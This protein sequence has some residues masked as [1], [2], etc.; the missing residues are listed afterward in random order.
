M[1]LD[2]IAHPRLL[3]DMQT[4]AKAVETAGFGSIWLTEGAR[5]A[6]LSCAAA[7]LATDRLQ[8]GTGIALAFARSPMVTAEIAWELADATGGRFVLGLGSQVKAHIERRYSAEFSPP[9]P[10]MKEYVKAVK[11]IFRAF[12]G[13]EKLAFEGRYYNFSLL[14]SMW[15]PGPIE[16][17]DPPIYVSAVLPYMSRL[18]GEI[19]DGIHVHPFHSPAFVRDVQRVS[20]EEGLARSG[21]N[22][23]A[24]TFQCPIMTAVGDSDEELSKTREHA[25][26]MIAFYGSTR[27]YSPVFEHHG[28]AGLSDELHARQKRGDMKG[29][30]GL[31]SDEVLEPYIVT[32]SWNDLGPKLVERYRDLAPKV[33]VTSYTAAENFDDPAAREKWSHVAAAMRAA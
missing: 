10:R 28:F 3:R 8:I 24:I 13:E 6:Y 17:P 23:D 21:R 19:A 30:I 22:L 2:I 14:P 4:H 26:T 11:A 31:V 29:M 25:R 7:A 12:R 15:S 5:T 20:I 1:E 9:G 32:S 33:R 16:A 27:T 18:V